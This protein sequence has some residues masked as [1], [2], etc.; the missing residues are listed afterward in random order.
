M[1]EK[2]AGIKFRGSLTTKCSVI[3]SS[4]TTPPLPPSCSK[5]HIYTDTSVFEQIDQIAVSVA[6]SEVTTFTELIRTLTVGA[7]SDVDKARSIYR[8]IL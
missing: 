7:R 2:A 4:Y 8:W 1:N 3:L 6:Q 5:R